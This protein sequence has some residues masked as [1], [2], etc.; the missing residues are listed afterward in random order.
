MEVMTINAKD[1]TAIV[2]ND[3]CH[4]CGACANVCHP[5]VI[6][7]YETEAGHI[8]PKINYEGCTACELCSAVCPG[9]EFGKTIT[10]IMEKVKDP[11]EGYVLKTQIGQSKDKEILENSQSGGIAS[12]IILHALESNLIDTAIVA[13]MSNEGSIHGDVI[14]AYNK[15]DVLLSQQSKYI[16]IPL[17]T[18][19]SI[20]KKKKERFALVGVSCHIHGLHNVLDRKPTL[21]K[22]FVFSIGL[23]C[24]RV[25]VNAGMDYLI[26]KAGVKKNDVTSFKFRDK[27][28]YGYPGHVHIRTLKK[29]YVLSP[30]ERMSIKDFFTPA[31]CRICFDKMN[32]GADITIGDPHGVE[33]VDRVKGESLVITRTKMGESILNSID[34]IKL[35]TGSYDIALS[36]QSIK[37]KKEDWRGYIEQWIKLNKPVPSYYKYVSSFTT[38]TIDKKYVLNLKQALFLRSIINRDKLITKYHQQVKYYDLKRKLLL[39]AIL[40]KRVLRK[41]KVRLSK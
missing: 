35:R 14:L 25:M 28:P 37:R 22:Q 21:K 10:N 15:E 23:V 32:I 40:I 34:S 4:S 13:V 19:L 12:A 27:K 39:P 24:D 8:F 20:V 18:A 31:R 26:D 5:E 7:F 2:S 11:F 1:I 17:L 33:N 41:I 29:S 6:S 36:G 30:E 38:K 16:P 3:L 9:I